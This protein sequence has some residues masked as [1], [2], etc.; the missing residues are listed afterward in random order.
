MSKENRGNRAGYSSGPELTRILPACPSSPSPAPC[1]VLARRSPHRTKSPPPLPHLHFL[2]LP[3]TLFQTSGFKPL[4]LSSS[5]LSSSRGVVAVLCCWR[6]RTPPHSSHY[7]RAS[8]RAPGTGGGHSKG[9]QLPEPTIHL[10]LPGW[11]Y[12]A[13]APHTHPHQVVAAT[14]HKNNKCGK[15]F[16]HHKDALGH[17]PLAGSFTYD[18]TLILKATQ[19]L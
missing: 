15:P 3:S 8:R 9:G 12:D 14:R 7:W 5:P 1:P 4:L 19:S 2:P 16:T 13:S 10:C 6:R 18:V 11:P 17:S